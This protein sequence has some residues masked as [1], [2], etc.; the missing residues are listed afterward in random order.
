MKKILL[1]CLIVSKVVIVFA[2]EEAIKVDVSLHTQV[3]SN[4]IKP[5]WLVANEWGR[6]E[7]FGYFGML[8]ELGAKYSVFDDDNFTLNAGIRGLVNTDISESMLQEAYLS[9]NAWFL[10]FSIGK[11]QYSPIIYNDELTSGS[12]LMN[13]NARPVPRLTVGIFDYLPLGFTKN[14]LEIKGGISQGWLNDD[15]IN[16]NNSANDVLLHEKFAYARLGNT[17]VKPYVGL[18]HSALFGGTRP[19]GSKIP[20]DFWATFMAKGSATLGGGEETNAAG[21]HMGMWDFGLNWA[22]EKADLHVYYQKPFADASGLK[23]YNRYDKDYYLG[24]LILP[25]EVEWLSGIS[26]E[27]FRTDHQSGYGIPDPLYPVE[28]GD[29]KQG[30]IIWMDDISDDFDGFMYE[31]F[32][33]SRVGW[34]QDEVMRY[35]EV[36]LNEGHMY[37]GRDDY[38]NNGFYYNGWVYDGMNMGT[39]VYHTADKVKRYADSWEYNDQVFFYNN[40]VN[41]FHIG[42]QGRLNSCLQYRIKSTYTI[43]KGTYGE[44]FRGRYS[45]QRTEDYF[46]SS[47]KKQVYSLVEL[48]WNMPWINNLSLKGKLAFD[49][50][51]LYNSVG[52][53]LSLTYVPTLNR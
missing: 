2:Q 4:D 3:S 22:T 41:G 39:A 27:V 46:F 13:S 33:E 29:H 12:F 35:L 32:G 18:V 11:Q 48:D 5:M 17:K 21:A 38:M 53:Q 50:G 19:N 42:V 51:Q 9:G 34:T 26:F 47:S 25:K 36:E 40:R 44:E 23:V 45:W 37:G 14:W 8:T 30:S 31:V 24:F 15:R 49:T 10:D 43:N 1:M 6:F 16:K 20:V 28:Y 52:G 7:Q